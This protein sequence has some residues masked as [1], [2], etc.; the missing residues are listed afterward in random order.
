MAKTY[1]CAQCLNSFRHD[2]ATCPNLACGSPRPA[3]GWGRLLAGGD[4][5]DRR[6]LVRERLAVGGAGITYR[7]RETDDNGAEIGP[8]LAVKV[9]FQRGDGTWKKRLANE[10]RVLQELEHPNIVESRGFVQRTG[11]PAYLVTVYEPGGN[12]YDHVRH[13]GALSVSA[14]VGILEQVLEGL[15]VAHRRGVIHRDLKPQNLFLRSHV[16]R[17][18]TPHVL[19]ADFGIAKLSG[20]LGEHLTTAGMFV[21]TPEFAAPEQFKGLPPEPPSDVFAAVCIFWFCLTGAP[22]V[23]LP[24]RTDLV[25]SLRA[26]REGLPPKVPDAVGRPEERELLQEIVDHTLLPNPEERWRIPTLLDALSTYQTP[27][28]EPLDLGPMRTLAPDALLPLD[29]PTPTPAPAPAVVEAEP[30][31]D[32]EPASAPEGAQPEP[33]P[34]ADDTASESAEAPAPRA[35]RV[36]LER[37]AEP[38]RPAPQ[39]ARPR[40]LDDS[41]D[42]L[43]DVP[44][45]D[46]VVFVGTSDEPGVSLDDLFAPP[47]S[48]PREEVVDVD[49]EPVA[50]PSPEPPPSPPSTEHRPEEPPETAPPPADPEPPPPLADAPAWSPKQPGDLPDLTTDADRVLALGSCRPADR[51]TLF[52][53]IDD[54]V[55]A[56]RSIAKTADAPMLCGACLVIAHFEVKRQAGWVRQLVGHREPDVRATAALALGSVGA[57]G[58]LAQLNRLLSDPSADVR[59]AAVHGLRALGART[60]RDDMVAGWL[61]AVANDADPRVRAAAK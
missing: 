53:A 29:D 37:T 48:P 41:L 38:A 34:V 60:G 24:D 59:L 10:A 28:A 3:E 16:D 52:E 45:D 15:A 32:A 22:P 20:F 13:H 6:Y 30:V 40:V 14:S 49:W 8:E 56:T 36:R 27:T 43:F 18:T 42:A 23:V 33:E 26:L 47:P 54:P 51:S 25:A 57:T 58:Q 2:G 4:L 21:G 12:L 44:A 9:I 31:T 7:A 46:G 61:Q 1:Y 11:Q 17:E 55:A 39:P 50:P 19:V 35:G 5:I